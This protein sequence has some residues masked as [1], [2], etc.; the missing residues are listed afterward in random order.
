MK[1]RAVTTRMKL[2]PRMNLRREN[3]NTRA[4]GRRVGSLMKNKMGIVTCMNF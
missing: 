3:P 4:K 1:S 2:D